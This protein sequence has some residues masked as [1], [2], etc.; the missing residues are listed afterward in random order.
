M[1]T[2]TYPTGFVSMRLTFFSLPRPETE[3]YTLYIGKLLGS[4]SFQD[5]Y[6]TKSPLRI[7]DL[8]S[9][10]GCISLLLHA[11]LAPHFQHLF[12]LGIDISTTAVNLAKRNLE[13]NIRLGL[14]SNRSRSEIHFHQG[15]VLGHYCGD[16]PGVEG[17]L[18]AY[19]PLGLDPSK[20]P[21]W[22]VLVSNPPYIS[23][24]SFEDGTTARS[25]RTFEPKLALVP[26][27]GM[28]YMTGTCK[29][30]DAFYHHLIALS[31]KLSTRLTVLECGSR[32]QGDRVAALCKDFMGRQQ[33]DHLRSMSID[34]WPDV[35]NGHY[36]NNGDEPCAVIM[37]RK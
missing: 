32:Q 36:C 4:R 16:I 9:G 24:I 31:F 35:E 1:P 12:V 29:Q 8:C 30:E 11:L 28:D 33:Q 34:I 17:I 27:A 37:R 3:S 22:D 5:G 2:H 26:P 13:H 21:E 19:V 15:D 25:V 7:L 6:H 14:L 10:T 20:T 23:P 18:E